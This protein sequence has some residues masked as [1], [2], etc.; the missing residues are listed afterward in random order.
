MRRPLVDEQIAALPGLSQEEL[1]RL[2]A[3]NLGERN[4]IKQQLRLARVNFAVNHIY[5]DQVWYA[6]AEGAV[7]HKGRLDQAI[8]LE[9][10][11]RRSQRAEQVR[12]KQTLPKPRPV[13]TLSG[14]FMDV[15]YEELPREVFEE[16]RNK[17]RARLDDLSGEAER[18][19]ANA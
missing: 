11:A 16:L 18:K 9:L 10:S 14:V 5:A 3:D 4:S 6:N 17:A 7:W 13:R 12:L 15:C 1:L 8:A 2:K 19:G